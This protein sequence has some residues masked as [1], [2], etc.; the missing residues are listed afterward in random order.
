[1]SQ[2]L[3]TL[4]LGIVPGPRPP[5][6][7]ALLG[8]KPFCQDQDA[9]E[10][11]VR[12][13][14]DKLD[15]YALHPDRAK[16]QSVQ[17]MM[18]ELAAARVALVNA[19]QKLRYDQTL[20]AALGVAAPAVAAAAKAG[21]AAA[22]GEKPRDIFIRR[23][24]SHLL[25]W[26]MDAHE[27]RLL[28]AEAAAVGISESEALKIIRRIDAE[29]ERIAGKWRRK[30]S[31]G[32]VVMIVAG[33]AAIFSFV[34]LPAMLR[35][36]TDARFD[37]HI[38]AA[39]DWIDKGKGAQALVEL[40]QA[41]QLKPAEALPKE[42]RLRAQYVLLVDA[43]AA[44]LKEGRYDL[45]SQKLAAAEQLQR[46]APA[47]PALRGQ[48][49][50]ALARQIDA[51]VAAGNP[52]QAI[53][54]LK[55][56]QAL[57]GPGPLVARLSE[58]IRA[59]QRKLVLDEVPKDLEAGNYAAART[60]IDDL[61]RLGGSAADAEDLL[62]RHG[63]KLVGKFRTQWA[64][65]QFP[66]AAQTASTIRIL[67]GAGGEWNIL[68]L[69]GTAPPVDGAAAATF[70]ADLM[71]VAAHPSTAPWP[72]FR[73][74]LLG[75]ALPAAMKSPAGDATAWQGAQLLEAIEGPG[76]IAGEWKAA[77]LR[78]RFERAKDQAEK[79]KISGQLIALLTAMTRQSLAMGNQ[80]QGQKYAAQANTAALLVFRTEQTEALIKQAAAAEALC[81]EILAL[82]P[83]A[84]SGD[85]DAATRLFHICLIELDDEDAAAPWV[86]KL[87]DAGTVECFNLA[88][89]DGGSL[90]A[91]QC[92]Q[93]EAWCKRL[94]QTPQISDAGKDRMLKRAAEYAALA[95]AQAAQ[96]P[97][98]PKDKAAPAKEDPAYLPDKDLELAKFAWV[99]GSSGDPRTPPQFGKCAEGY[100]KSRS[101]S[102]AGQK[103]P[104][105]LNFR[106]EQPGSNAKAEV[107]YDL[108]PQW[109][110]FVAHVGLDDISSLR[111]APNAGACIAEVFIDGKGVFKSQP[112][113][114]NAPAIPI[115][116]RIPPGSKRMRLTAVISSDK[117]RSYITWGHPGF[118]ATAK[119]TVETSPAPARAAANPV[120]PA[121]DVF[122]GDLKPVAAAAFWGAVT[123]DH[124]PLD[125]QPLRIA[126]ADYPR[127]LGLHAPARVTYE[128]MRPY[129]DFVARVGVHSHAIKSLDGTLGGS[130][131]A[132][133]LIDDKT[134]AR[135]GILRYNDPPWN[136][137]VPI[138]AGAKRITLVTTDA[139]D[140]S[141][142]DLADWTAAGFLVAGGTTATTPEPGQPPQPSPLDKALQEIQALVKAQQYP[143]AS[144]KIAAFRKEYGSTATL[145]KVVAELST[146]F[147][148]T[149]KA[150]PQYPKAL[151][152]AQAIRAATDPEA[153]YNVNLLMG[154]EGPAKAGPG[155][156]LGMARTMLD[157]AKG[158]A[159]DAELATAL[160][161]AAYDYAL[162]HPENF[163]PALKLLTE[164][165][166]PFR[167]EYQSAL[168]PAY[169][170]N[171]L[172]ASGND[173]IK[174]GLNL[175]DLLMEVGAAA[176]VAARWDD[177]AVAYQEARTLATEVESPRQREIQLKLGVIASRQGYIK[178]AAEDV[179]ALQGASPADATALRKKLFE[180]LYVELGDAAEA[181]KYADADER[182][183]EPLRLMALPP[184]DLAPEQCA[185]LDR[186]YRALGAGDKV[187]S[188][189][190]ERMA[191]KAR[192]YAERRR[193]LLSG[194]P[195]TVNYNTA[196]IE[197]IKDNRT[198]ATALTVNGLKQALVAKG[199][200][201]L[202]VGT[203]RE[204]NL[205]VGVK[206]DGACVASLDL[207]GLAKFFANLD[208]L[209]VGLGRRPAT[210]APR[211]TGKAVLKLAALNVVRAH[212]IVVGESAG[213]G[214][215]GMSGELTLAPST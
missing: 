59:L 173:K 109:Q 28:V 203:E 136:V 57:A 9:I 49:L 118:Q 127:G 81:K 26:A 119:A 155:P 91:A 152:L 125:N 195:L 90:S 16:R 183:V 20:A 167:S 67:E 12:R 166:A 181:A 96:A 5:H 32:I 137:R 121:P 194:R 126:G 188:A 73:T 72:A 175:L 213:A 60:K 76:G 48:A 84:H 180:L 105:G 64:A 30:V 10:Q 43:A 108:Q 41:Q 87:G 149:L 123:V 200:G 71:A 68:P 156:S 38:A 192:E 163:E 160:R 131:A 184:K 209:A 145:D 24:R 35:S 97:K 29:A 134:V 19:E 115:C 150:P 85:R 169:R 37:A 70:A 36:K 98:T 151:V 6:H 42:L 95:A 15:Q 103:F 2:D 207:S 55:G 117:T 122:L 193:G 210:D 100:Y 168:A 18:N 162:A 208:Q 4:W 143:E 13:R 116:V 51:A 27:E 93:V 189:G 54:L 214:S 56:V 102:V 196:A 172:A 94:A 147:L 99:S 205:A 204:V 159:G 191:A 58:S 65:R 158:L 69:L 187:S 129:K 86:E 79:E 3:Y 154:L 111:N 201:A 66:D 92:A 44:A 198:V 89:L 133:V 21:A 52:A 185:V 80:A 62:H 171:Y 139:G 138:P 63:A 211:A 164:L 101:P 212:S 161:R 47:A 106:A 78:A 82:R 8:I 128:L 135:S 7:Y 112:L 215:L 11:A 31:V 170:R 186:W 14:M 39:R 197:E 25:K 77:I 114:P 33:A 120:P 40:D 110:A 146:L 178:Q 182:N 202:I 144:Q 148:N 176:I 88:T 177:A 206:P 190:A 140:T 50:D 83:K 113:Q 174:A 34:L 75:A 179:K 142:P 74:A 23:L 141:N 46:D 157:A 124:S 199:A 53:A 132:A 17:N 153:P 104:T 165:A 61:K 45:A 22:P 1:M 130:I 107:V